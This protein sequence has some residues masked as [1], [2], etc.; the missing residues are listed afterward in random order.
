MRV[1]AD[2]VA[3]LKR[4]PLRALT[5]KVEKLGGVNFGQGNNLL[6]TPAAL[7]QAAHESMRDGRNDY[8]IQEGIP[9]LRRAI[10]D[11]LLV[12]EGMDADPE[13]ELRITSGAT[14][15]FFSACRGFLQTGA[16]AVVLEPYYPYHVACLAL[17]GCTIRYCRLEAPHWDLDLERIERVLTDATR[18]LVFCNP[19]NPTGRVYPRDQ[20]AALAGLCARR[21]VQLVS[22][23]VYGSLTYDGHTHVPV[24]TIPD[25]GRQALVVTSFSKSYAITGWRVGYM[26]GP[27]EV[28][29]RLTV[30]H[31]AMYVCAPRPLQHAVTRVLPQHAEFVDS[32]HAQFDWRRRMLLDAL[33]QSGFEPLPVQGTYYV[34]ARYG[35]RYGDVPSLEAC[36]RLLDELHVASVPGAAFYHD[37]H[38]P[39][40]LRFC[41]ALPAEDLERG[42]RLLVG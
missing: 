37:G 11:R 26:V 28:I 29:E 10:R 1:F 33:D 20:V 38:D 5:D 2:C 16:E 39:K 12:P 13:T 30:V 18:L 8:S 31:D 35:E 41:F 32:L 34:M 27:E 21:G 24:A 15:A 14:G 17:T 22:D 7:I 42:A 4:S 9:E 40:L 23:E 25:A 3:S 36:Q 6:P 19:N